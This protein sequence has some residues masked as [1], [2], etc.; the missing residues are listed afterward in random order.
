MHALPTSPAL[1]MLAALAAHASE[2][3]AP[4]VAIEPGLIRGVRSAGVEAFKGI[5]LAQPPLGELRWRPPQPVSPWQEVR[6]A[7]RYGPDCMQ[8]AFE[9]SASP[10]GAP[11]AEDCLYLNVWKP[12]QAAGRTPVLVW[13]Y[14]GG[15]VN[16]RSS[17]A[18]Y[19][20]EPLARQGVLVVSFNY[21]VGRFGFFA[22]PQL[23]RDQGAHEALGNYGLMDQLAALQWVQRNIGAFG[24]DP[25]QVT[26]VG[27]S[28]GGM[29]IHA[30]LTSPQNHGLFQRAVIQSGGDGQLF[31]NDLGKAEQAGLAFAATQGIA[32]DDP[33]AVARL[34]RL[35]AAQV[36]G[37]LN[38]STLF[39]PPQAVPTYTLPMR[40]GQVAVDALKA[41]QAR[42]FAPVPV[43]LGVV[44]DD[45]FGAEGA[46]IKGAR[47]VA[48]LLVGRGVPLY[49]YRFSYVAQ[50]ARAQSPQGARHA[51]EIPYFLRTLDAW[52][53]PALSAQDRRASELASAYLVNFVRTGNPNGAG[54]A[55]WPR[56]ESGQPTVLDFTADAGVRLY[57]D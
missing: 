22:H 55:R 45:L 7:E 17:A 32:A 15:F 41:Y 33:Q 2:L 9:S 38:L 30:L 56:Y 51:S 54:L 12:A 20:G 19:S 31:M 36:T 24:G 37:E 13:I 40:D 10:A 1:L 21:R 46:M 14:G 6:S 44:S 50:A 53:G 5:P 27:E 47:T 42:R 49:R 28:A 18:V 48:D 8:K 11:P 34:R 52:L 57:G 35:S 39:E 25:G 43:M 26:V 3:Q 23:S 4:I 16:G 29:S